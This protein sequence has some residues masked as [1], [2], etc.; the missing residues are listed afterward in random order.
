V[1]CFGFIFKAEN[2]KRANDSRDSEVIVIESG[3]PIL[4]MVGIVVT[5]GDLHANQF[6]PST[7]RK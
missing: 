6:M 4:G 2:T 7:A 1:K 5:F 3:V